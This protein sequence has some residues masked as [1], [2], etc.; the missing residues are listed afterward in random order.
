MSSN[1]DT[2]KAVLIGAVVVLVVG[3][4][5]ILAYKGYFTPS[6]PDHRKSETRF[7]KFAQQAAETPWES[8]APT[9]LAEQVKSR[10]DRDAARF[11]DKRFADLK[12]RFQN[13]EQMHK[14]GKQSNTE[15]QAALVALGN[16]LDNLEEEL[17][18]EARSNGQN[19]GAPNGNGGAV[20]PELPPSGE[21]GEKGPGPRPGSKKGK[22]RPPN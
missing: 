21:P 18:P 14:Q 17:D 16:N 7:T 22:R 4:T 6:P 8:E 12:T 13:L 3:S 2:N 19:G 20:R 11:N 15:Y 5:S 10:I 9:A 1:S